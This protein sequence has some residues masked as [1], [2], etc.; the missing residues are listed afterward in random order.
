MKIVY[1]SVNFL[2][3]IM[4]KALDQI[5]CLDPIN[6]DSIQIAYRSIR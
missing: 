3:D 1:K 6:F 4:K 2:I 5:Q